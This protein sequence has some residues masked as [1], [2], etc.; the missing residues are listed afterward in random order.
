MGRTPVGAE[1][2]RSL[3]PTRAEGFRYLGPRAEA[4][5]VGAR[6]GTVTGAAGTR[7][8]P[9][10]G[11]GSPAEWLCSTLKAAAAGFWTEL[12]EAAAT[13]WP[14]KVLFGHRRRAGEECEKVGRVAV[15]GS[16]EGCFELWPGGR[17][18]GTDSLHSGRSED[19]SAAICYP[20]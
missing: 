14:G 11:D 1:G 15:A 3:S 7:V 10:L 8:A 16:R 13:G 9:E 5:A 18:R 19:D 4:S 2:G 12:G 6:G 20:V 17:R